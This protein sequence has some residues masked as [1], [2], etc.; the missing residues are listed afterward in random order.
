MKIYIIEDE[1]W[2][3]IEIEGTYFVFQI[4]EGEIEKKILF[5]MEHLKIMIIEEQI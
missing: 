1:E 2:K 3:D 5:H 4:K